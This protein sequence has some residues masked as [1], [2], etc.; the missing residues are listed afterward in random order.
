MRLLNRLDDG[1]DVHR[2]DGSEVDHLR[3]DAVFRL[4]LLGGDERLSD[5]A[6]ESDDRQ[7][8]PCTFN[9]GFAELHHGKVSTGEH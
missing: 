9:L 8:F 5:A 6:R 2:L 1:F 7:V 3:L 4:E